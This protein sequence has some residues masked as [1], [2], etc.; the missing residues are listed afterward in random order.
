M[1]L[2]L[3]RIWFLELPLGQRS[4]RQ[5][6]AKG[7]RPLRE[8]EESGSANFKDRGSVGLYF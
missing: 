3:E 4:R 8:A 7:S 2:E 6:F 5:T 1:A